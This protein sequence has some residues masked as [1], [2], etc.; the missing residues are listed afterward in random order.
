VID[1]VLQEFDVDAAVAK[2]NAAAGRRQA[3]AGPSAVTTDAPPTVS[4]IEPGDN[5]RV[6]GDVVNVH[7][8][9][10]AHPGSRIKQVHFLVNGQEAAVQPGFVV[11]SD[12]EGVAE[13]RMPVPV[14][15]N[16]ERLAVIADGEQASSDPATVRLRPAT[17]EPDRKPKL[18]V[19][20]AGISNYKNGNLKL[21]FAARD[22]EEIVKV[23]RQQ[24]QGKLY[25]DVDAQL[26]PDDQAT[27]QGL[28]AGLQWLDEK[29]EP[30]DVA[31]VFFSGHG[32]ND[33]ND[34]LVLLPY[35]ADAST[36]AL[37][38]HTGFPYS[39]LQPTLTKLAKRAKVLVFLD[40]CHSGSVKGVTADSSRVIADL[41]AEENGVIVFASSQG[42]QL[43]EEYEPGQHGA[44]TEA[45]IEGLKGG[46]D[47]DKDGVVRFSELKRFVGERVAQLTEK[48]QQPVAVIPEKRFGDPPLLVVR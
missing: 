38:Q 3:P 6:E 43:S 25:A 47:Y 23:L 11:P 1:R 46:A 39:G 28:D 48:R 7:Y 21:R 36:D 4:I 33:R 9:V 26:L 40:A 45:L 8:Y 5:A 15:G 24:R 27:W 20:A 41:A 19:L 42:R 10:Q 12:A 18:W 37:V 2:A 29:V 13:R 32:A 30:G 35:E 22:A 16:A 31:V 44:F 17:A 14:E 34:D